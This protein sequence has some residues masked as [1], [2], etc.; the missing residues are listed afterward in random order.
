MRILAGLAAL[1]VSNS[2]FAHSGH[3]EVSAI[4]HGLFSPLNGIEPFLAAGVGA[5]LIWL[6]HKRQS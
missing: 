6:V 4:H 5:V 2:A 1:L 3:G